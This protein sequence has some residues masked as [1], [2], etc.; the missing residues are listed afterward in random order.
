LVIDHGRHTGAKPG[1]VLR[2]AGY[3]TAEARKSP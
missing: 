3:E 2:G 1:N